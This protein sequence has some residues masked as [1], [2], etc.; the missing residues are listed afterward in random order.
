MTSA[1]ETEILD[2]RDGGTRCPHG[3]MLF[4]AVFLGTSEGVKC[5]RS[6]FQFC[7]VYRRYGFGKQASV[8]TK[9]PQF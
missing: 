7:T 4:F 9:I 6:I 2:K 3:K 8:S 1:K 5:K